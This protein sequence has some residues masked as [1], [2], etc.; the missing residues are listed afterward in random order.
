[1]FCMTKDKI[2]SSKDQAKSNPQLTLKR[3]SHQVQRNQQRS[4]VHYIKVSI[5][6]NIWNFFPNMKGR[7]K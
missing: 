3:Q 1:M 7:R 6:K 5:D 4:P 2:Y